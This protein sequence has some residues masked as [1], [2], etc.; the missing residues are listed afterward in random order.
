MATIRGGGSA[1]LYWEA[2]LSLRETASMNSLVERSILLLHCH[3]IKMM[4]L[5]FDVMSVLQLDL[6]RACKLG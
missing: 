4:K 1:R 3:S 5:P 2:T 6:G